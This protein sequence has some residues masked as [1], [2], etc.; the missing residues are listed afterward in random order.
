MPNQQL[1]DYIKQAT[2]QGQSREQVKATLLGAGWQEVDIEMA[3]SGN[4]ASIPTPK[5]APAFIPSSPMQSFGGGQTAQTN[6][7]QVTYGGF[8]I[9]YLAVMLDGFFV[10]LIILLPI[11]IIVILVGVVSGALS[12][13]ISPGFS[14]FATV[15][16]I[17]GLIL[18]YVYFIVLTNRRQTTGDNRQET[19][20]S[21]RSF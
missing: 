18:Y 9:R 6:T 16:N 4:V 13:K 11:A 5:P 2:E 1:I 20:R 17:L 10:N 14:I 21:A 7:P 8:W 3:F 15:M 19:S 12:G